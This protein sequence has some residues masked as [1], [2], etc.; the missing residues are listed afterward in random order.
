MIMSQNRTL[1]LK[2][3]GSEASVPELQLEGNSIELS[4]GN[5]E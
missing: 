2:G 4:Y 1:T 5:I 3:S